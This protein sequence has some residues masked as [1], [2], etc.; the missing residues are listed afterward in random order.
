MIGAE[1]TYTG[2]DI[3]VFRLQQLRADSA[4]KIMRPSLRAGAKIELAEAQ[5]LAPGAGF[6]ASKLKIKPGKSGGRSKGEI[7]MRVAAGDKDWTE[8][9]YFLPFLLLGHKTRAKLKDGRGRLRAIFQAFGE[10]IVHRAA[11]RVAGN[12]FIK[13]AYE[14]TKDQALQ[15]VIDTAA[16]R[17]D[18]L[19]AGQNPA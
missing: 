7:R 1:A 17:I 14:K 15:V 4:K 10:T 5:K 18:K 19:A 6:L 11:V 16:K 12:N 2:A 9:A 8:R 13:R 3:V